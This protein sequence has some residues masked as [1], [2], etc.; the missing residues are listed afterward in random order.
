MH[1]CGNCNWGRA[2]PF[3]GIHKW[4]FRC[5]VGYLSRCQCVKGWERGLSPPQHRSP[6]RPAYARLQH[7]PLM[8]YSTYSLYKNLEIGCAQ[9]APYSQLFLNSLRRESKRI[10]ILFVSY[11][12][13]SVNSPTPFI[14]I[15]RFIFPSIY[16]H[17]LH[18]FAYKY[19]IW[20]KT[21][22]CWS[23]CSFQS[24]SP[25]NN[26]AESQTHRALLGSRG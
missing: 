13:V 21:N 17:K 23:E 5:S 15:I 16:S 1:E 2:I 24:E 7:T 9:S 4:V 11:S 10:W 12:H 19:L 20:C 3:L 14:R 25:L 8:Q 26:K 18:K 22:T 6:H